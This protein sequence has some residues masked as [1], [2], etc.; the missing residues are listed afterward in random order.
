MKKYLYRYHP[1]YNKWVKEIVKLDDKL[2]II[3]EWND[4][5]LKSFVTKEKEL[6]NIWE[7][8]F[9]IFKKRF[10][11]IHSFYLLFLLM[12]LISSP[13]INSYP[14]D[15]SINKPIEFITYYDMVQIRKEYIRTQDFNYELFYEYMELISIRNKNIVISQSILETN[16]FSSDIFLENNN[17][18][19]MKE[20][21]VRKTTAMGTNRGHAIYNH[22]T[23]SVDDYKYWYRYMTRNKEYKNYYNFLTAMGYAEDIYYIPKLKTIK[24]NLINNKTLL[25]YE[26]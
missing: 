14:P 22:W 20:P 7:Y 26:N 5:T 18:F 13:T 25:A 6:M 8:L 11:R 4:A 21:R 17:L 3:S 12:F 1:I 9:F 24:N 10:I 16:W 19:G 15:M 2:T 23:Y